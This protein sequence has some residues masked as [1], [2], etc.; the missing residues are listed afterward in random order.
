MVGSL[1]TDSV[2]NALRNSLTRLTS[3]FHL[4]LG[5]VVL[6]FLVNVTV[7]ALIGSAAI[8]PLARVFIPL[9]AVLLLVLV[10]TIVLSREL[11][12]AVLSEIVPTAIVLD[13][14][15]NELALPTYLR[16]PNRF[17][18]RPIPLPITVTCLYPIVCS[19]RNVSEDQRGLTTILCATLRALSGAKATYRLEPFDTTVERG[20]FHSMSS[21]PL[22]PHLKVPVDSCVGPI[23]DTVTVREVLPET[24][25][26]LPSVVK[27]TVSLTDPARP[28]LLFSSTVAEL[29]VRL[30]FQTSNDLT[31]CGWKRS[32][33]PNQNADMVHGYAF[34]VRL[35]LKITSY[36]VRRKPRSNRWS[37]DDIVQ[38][39]ANL[40][41]WLREYLDWLDSDYQ[42]PASER[43]TLQINEPPS[44][45]PGDEVDRQHN[46]PISFL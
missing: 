4:I 29:D 28:S 7:A 32:F 40:F 41:S 36:V 24:V 8:S 30:R 22:R 46:V 17:E 3:V 9:V 21:A 13:S 39:Y 15:R 42:I 25:I 43:Y 5:G 26:E 44:Y 14:H 37:A 1:Q 20:P 35:R 19:A 11:R 6:A 38:W 12:V 33:A 45:L 10:A 34:M 31:V 23:L 27:L 2:V 16:L 18:S